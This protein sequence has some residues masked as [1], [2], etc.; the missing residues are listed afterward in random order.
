MFYENKSNTSAVSSISLFFC[1]DAGV[2][3]SSSR[4]RRRSTATAKRVGWRQRCVHVSNVSVQFYFSV[5]HELPPPP[6]PFADVISLIHSIKMI[7]RSLSKDI[8]GSHR[9]PNKKEIR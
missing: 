9:Q 1:T 5:V 3:F 6:P 8:D 4:F 2:V 7:N